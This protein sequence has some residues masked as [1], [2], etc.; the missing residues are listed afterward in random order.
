MLN[1]QNLKSV[2]QMFPFQEY[3]KVFSES[4]QYNLLPANC[5][6]V[7]AVINALLLSGMSWV[8]QTNSSLR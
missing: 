2:I 6:V 8:F 3:A 4:R 5:G 7:E 1:M